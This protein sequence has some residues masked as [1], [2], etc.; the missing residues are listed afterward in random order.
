MAKSDWEHALRSRG[1]IN[2]A[3]SSAPGS[4]A[5]GGYQAGEIVFKAA[6]HIKT[7]RGTK[8]VADYIA[9]HGG[10][11]EREAFDET[12]HRLTDEEIHRYIDEE[13]A[14]KA[15]CENLSPAARAAKGTPAFKEM[16]DREKYNQRQSS[17]F[18]LSLPVSHKDVNKDQLHQIAQDFLGPFRESDHKALY[19]IH[20]HQTNP[21]IHFVISFRDAYRTK[22]STLNMTT[23]RL[24]AMREHGA[25]VARANGVEA[26]ATRRESRVETVEK[27][28]RG[29]ESMRTPQKRKWQFENEKISRHSNSSLLERQAPQWYGRHGTEFEARRV[30]AL[31][32]G[33]GVHKAELPELKQEQQQ[34]MSTWAQAYEDPERAKVSFLEMAAE[35]ERLAFWNS[36]NRP[37]V[38]GQPK[39]LDRVN[40]KHGEGYEALTM[41]QLKLSEN[42]KREA[43]A[44]ID[45]A[46]RQMDESKRAANFIYTRSQKAMQAPGQAVKEALIEKYV[47]TS[48]AKRVGIDVDRLTFEHVQRGLG[49]YPILKE[50][51]Q[52][53]KRL[54]LSGLAE[55]V[56]QL[57]SKLK[58]PTPE[59][60][61]KDDKTLPHNDESMPF[62]SKPGYDSAQRTQEIYKS[63]EKASEQR[64]HGN[65]KD[66]VRERNLE[67][68]E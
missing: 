63:I 61:H 50:P 44:E 53:T 68:P 22:G 45:C 27:V 3:P 30:G 58:P 57:W 32:K 11:D 48:M 65:S 46:D 51:E 13:F 49:K 39:D 14:L 25:K 62:A 24:D 29:D 40:P 36:H 55:N 54:T 10:N 35:N 2:T 66:L 59:L 5:S 56:R 34:A 12:G 42:W 16:T 38:F 21:H 4:R 64:E 41:R 31:M 43:R 7:V 8:V 6:S 52:E 19:A 17:H 37:Q 1:S 28:L 15:D 33:F 47:V 20:S 60:R 67:V 23:P 18:I 26:Q 9:S